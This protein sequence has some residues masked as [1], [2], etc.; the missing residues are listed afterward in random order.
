MAQLPPSQLGLTCFATQT[1]TIA[2]H[3][4][5]PQYRATALH[6]ALHAATRGP[7]TCRHVDVEERLVEDMTAR[8]LI[9]LDALTAVLAHT[10]NEH[11]QALLL[12][13]DV[14]LLRAR[15]RGLTDAERR[16]IETYRLETR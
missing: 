10:D 3:L 11:G 7:T 9:E 4:T 12:Q 14:P 8:R 15:L 16:I 6:E 5:Y 1:I 13:V 2:P